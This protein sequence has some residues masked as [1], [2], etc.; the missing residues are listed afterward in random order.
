MPLTAKT[1]SQGEKE[2]KLKIK[3]AITTAKQEQITTTNKK[4][5]VFGT[6]KYLFKVTAD[7]AE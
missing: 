5:K 1:E 6:V 2:E 3:T 7:Y 4:T